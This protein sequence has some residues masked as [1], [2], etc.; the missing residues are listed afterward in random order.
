MN[1]TKSIRQYWPK[2]LLLILSAWIGLY[3][4]VVVPQSRYRGISEQKASGL[5]AATGW[6]PISLWQ[7]TLPEMSAQHLEA[8]TFSSP[9][10]GV[11]GGVPGGASSRSGQGS[12]SDRKV[13]RTSSLE[14]EV[15]RPAE[16]AESIRRLAERLGG[17][18]TDSEISGDENVQSGTVNLLV[19]DSGFEQARSAI[20][21]L[22]IRVESERIE[23][24]DI[25]K[26]YVDNAVRLLTLRAQEQQYLAIL[27]R[28]TRIS[29]VVDIS[30]KLTSVRG[31]IEQS[32]AESKT[33]S[34]QASMVA[35]HIWLR[36]EMDARVFGLHWRP[37]YMIKFGARSG[38]ESLG[39][40]LSNMIVVIFNCP[41]LRFGSL[42]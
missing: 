14:L 6:E 3:V 23:R 40:Y 30:E 1:I 35:I 42:Q 19:P 21:Q 15:R 7:E 34:T 41:R 17:Y 38:F 33:L 10:D 13:T 27:K 12:I 24:R 36:S 28:A 9:S 22:S 31:Q 5:S 18:V 20:K 2:A 32:E 11:V 37:L 29:D 4:S 39:N 16:T 8:A 25:T 26:Q